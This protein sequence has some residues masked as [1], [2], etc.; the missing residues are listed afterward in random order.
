MNSCSKNACTQSHMKTIK[1]NVVYFEKSI[2]AIN[3]FDICSPIGINIDINTGQIT[4][5]I[6]IEIL[7]PLVLNPTIE[8]NSI[9]LNGIL[10]VKLIFKN[11]EP[12]PCTD[13]KKEFC[14]EVYIPIQCV[15]FHD[16]QCNSPVKIETN[17]KILS[18]TISGFPSPNHKEIGI[19]NILTIKTIIKIDCMLLKEENL[20][21]YDCN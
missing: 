8:G 18:T 16:M 12:C 5:P 20:K 11:P 6:F 14:E 15:L 19:K 4:S 7:K 2:E 10:L 9:I 1:A 17:N 3:D 21:V 13:L